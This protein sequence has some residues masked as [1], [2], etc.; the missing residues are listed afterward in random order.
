MWVLKSYRSN[1]LILTA[2]IL[3]KIGVDTTVGLR[4]ILGGGKGGGGGGRG[5][6]KG[7]LPGFRFNK[8]A[9]GGN[10][11]FTNGT[12][13]I[14]PEPQ[15]KEVE[16]NS[17]Q[18]GKVVIGGDINVGGKGLFGGK[19]QGLRLPGLGGG[20]GGSGRGK[21]LLRGK[22]P[23]L[24]LPGFGGGG[25]G[26]RG[27]GFLGG[28]GLGG[29]SSSSGGRKPSG[30]FSKL[31]QNLPCASGL[32]SLPIISRIPGIPSLRF[33]DFVPSGVNTCDATCG[34]KDSNSC[35]YNWRDSLMGFP[36]LL[37][38]CFCKNVGQCPPK[39]ILFGGY[40][41]IQCENVG[42]QRSRC[43]CPYGDD[44]YKCT[45]NILP[46]F[47]RKNAYYCACCKNAAEGQ[48]LG[49]YGG[50]GGAAE[51]GEE[52]AILSSSSFSAPDGGY[53]YPVSSSST[54]FNGEGGY[55]ASGSSTNFEGGYS[56][57]SSSSLVEVGGYQGSSSS[58][59]GAV[60][61]TNKNNDDIIS[62]K[63]PFAKGKPLG[64]DQ[65]LYGHLR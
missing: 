25:E 48:V 40:L 52:Q 11:H 45:I 59:E 4:G 15:G 37:F 29:G 22:L 41:N 14:F 5:G 35:T 28:K 38:H 32:G 56:A 65:Y 61:D 55:S 19:L 34:G 6:I 3:S 42:E 49:G 60:L 54:N 17:G 30:V 24:R 33:P 50:G 13:S 26:G 18:G 31:S 46:L 39:K 20:G 23:K 2:L 62:D 64:S 10:Q 44:P 7:F 27:L 12:S 58:L 43:K 1:A 57:A 51:G 53:S 8:F 21:G 63:P 9:G 16:F 47:Q 36:L